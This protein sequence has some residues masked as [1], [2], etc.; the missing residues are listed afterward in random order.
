MRKDLLKVHHIRHMQD[1]TEVTSKTLTQLVR[2]WEANEQIDKD[3]SPSYLGAQSDFLEFLFDQILG[4]TRR[5]VRRELKKA[6]L[7]K[8][9]VYKE[10]QGTGATRK[11]NNYNQP[12]LFESYRYD[13]E[14]NLVRFDT[15]F[16]PFRGAYTVEG[17]E[18]LPFE[19]TQPVAGGS[20]FFLF[21][22][23][24]VAILKKLRQKEIFTMLDGAYGAGNGYLRKVYRAALLYFYDKFEDHQFEAFAL[25][26]FLLLA[27]FRASSSS[28]YDASVIKFQ[29]GDDKAKFDPFKSILLAY[30]P[31]H[32][33]EEMRTYVRYHC[34]EK[35]NWNSDLSGTKK[36]FYQAGKTLFIQPLD[37]FIGEL[38]GK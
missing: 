31:E 34:Q 8:V 21:A 1:E 33:I 23:K 12:P 3:H 25:H 9:D 13:L 22:Q 32:I 15:K 6:D 20:G 16:A 24:Y 36:Q 30:S 2:Q 10:F 29:W 26:L 4:I 27:Y 17:F 38:W 14:K 5:A 11:L 18:F 28:V 37:T 7:Q 35:E 19:V